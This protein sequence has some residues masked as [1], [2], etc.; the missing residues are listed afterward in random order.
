MLVW[1]KLLLAFF[2]TV[3]NVLNSLN[4]STDLIATSLRQ[5]KADSLA[6]VGEMLREHSADLGSLRHLRIRRV[7]SSWVLSNPSPAIFLE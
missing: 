6:K 3:G 4:V 7:N 2:N 5:S 1:P